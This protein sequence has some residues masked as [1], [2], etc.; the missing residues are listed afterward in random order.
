MVII[1]L[2]QVA[3]E[4]IEI[5]ALIQNTADVWFCKQVAIMEKMENA[6][7]CPL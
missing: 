2:V 1:V 3:M 5:L 4:D 7:E 6:F